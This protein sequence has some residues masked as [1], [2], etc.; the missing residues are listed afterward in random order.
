VP[1]IARPNPAPE[2]FVWVTTA[3][4]PASRGTGYDAGQQGWKL[5]AVPGAES[6]TFEQIRGRRSACGVSPS[7]GWSLDLFIEDRCLRCV[8]KLGLPLTANEQIAER[9]RRGSRE[10]FRATGQ[11][12]S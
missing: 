2:G 9:V 8:K 12:R 6:E 5:H 11:A 10:W 4:N 1:Y 3:P 7:H